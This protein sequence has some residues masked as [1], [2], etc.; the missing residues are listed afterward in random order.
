MSQP[1]VVLLEDV[2]CPTGGPICLQVK[3]LE[4][5]LGERVAVVG[6]NGAGK[7]TLLRLISCFIRPVAGRVVVLGR[8]LDSPLPAHGM[9]ALRR[10]VGQIMQD[11][12]PVERLSVLENVLI[13][14]LGR[15]R[16][17]RGWT[18]CFPPGE[19]EAAETALRAVG[20]LKRAGTRAD[21][22]SGG[23]RQKVALARLLMQ[24]PRL[25][26]ADEPTAALD[27]V[28]AREVCQLLVEAS[29]AATLVSVVHNPALLPLLANR[30]IGMKKGSI[31]FD[32][33]I[34]ELH[35]N[36]LD[37]LYSRNENH[38][39]DTR[40]AHDFASGG[41]PTQGCLT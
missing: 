40:A 39:Q 6:P 34:A 10:E 41:I 12:H 5:R 32:L 31:D 14:C 4:I 1:A 7:S 28:A 19:V 16:G 26:L 17:W 38:L 29:A 20:L 23:E 37:A 11:L 30:V 33:P 21:A 15:T 36:G 22:L 13:G 18:R 24:R 25:I 2:R 27:P 3:H 35:G 8:S 9:R